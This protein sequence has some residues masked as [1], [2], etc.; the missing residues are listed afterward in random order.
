MSEGILGGLANPRAI[1]IRR[2]T[3][4]ISPATGLAGPPHQSDR[5]DAEALRQ[6][7]LH[8]CWPLERC[9]QIGVSAGE[10]LTI[11]TDLPNS[12]DM[13]QCELDKGNI[14]EFTDDELSQKI[15]K[16]WRT[17]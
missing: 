7:P 8:A 13:S 1:L 5:V 16:L 2:S 11:L 15:V 4:G 10:D 14:I 3:A 12:G 6:L 17:S 9:Q